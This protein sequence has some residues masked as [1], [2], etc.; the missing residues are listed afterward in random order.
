MAE[1]SILWTTNGTGD[2]AAD[3]TSTQWVN[4]FSM[5]F[6]RDNATE[7]VAVVFRNSLAV[8]STG[9]NNI[10]V[11]SGGAV[12]R[13]FLYDNTD[14]VD[15]TVSSPA[16]DTGFRAVLR[17]DWALQTVRVV[18]VLNTTGLTDPPALTQV[19]GT[20]WEI[21]LATGVITSAGAIT[22]LTDARVFMHYNTAVSTAML[23]ALSVTAAKI[24]ADAVTT[25]KILDANVTTAKIANANVTAD[26]IAAAVAGNGLAGGA[27]SALSVTVDDSTIEINSDTLRLKDGGVSKTKLANVYA[28]VATRQG[29]SATDWATTGTGT[30]TVTVARTQM[31]SIEVVIGAG[32]DE[33]SVALNFPSNFTNT[34]I[35]TLGW[36]AT[37]QSTSTR[38]AAVV[39]WNAVDATGFDV[40]AY[41]RNPADNADAWAVTVHWTATSSALA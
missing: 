18:V 13:G 15:K 33:G 17:A 7:G 4:F 24:A 36:Q 25:A 35:I 34:P 8:S 40:W 6:L 1:S 22:G 12:V 29:G 32:Q 10:R 38:K 30:Q 28:D 21:S 14:N 20:T 27:G 3:I 2:G 19:F 11:A 31:G 9:A 16:A 37:I 39:Q 23:E 41:R 26:K 5:L